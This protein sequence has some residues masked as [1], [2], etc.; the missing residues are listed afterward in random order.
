[1]RLASTLD[2]NLAVDVQIRAFFVHLRASGKKKSD[3]A[4]FVCETKQTS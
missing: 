2:H 3:F 4:L 1:V